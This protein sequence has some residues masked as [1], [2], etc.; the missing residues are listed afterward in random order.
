MDSEVRFHFI[1]D[2]SEVLLVS[3]RNYDRIDPC[4]TGGEKLA[5]DATDRQYAS[6]K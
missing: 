4:T 3:L 2:L 1:W 5:L 6:S